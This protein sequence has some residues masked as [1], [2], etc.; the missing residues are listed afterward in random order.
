[1]EGQGAECC[2]QM[3][4]IHTA[5]W[6][7][8]SVTNCMQTACKEVSG[9]EEM[10]APWCILRR[11]CILGNGL[12][13]VEDT[14]ARMESQANAVDVNHTSTCNCIQPLA[15]GANAPEQGNSACVHA[16]ISISSY[17][18]L[19]TERLLCNS[20][21]AKQNS[22][23]NAANGATRSAI[24]GPHHMH[25]TPTLHAKHPK[26]TSSNSTHGAIQ[27]AP[28]LTEQLS[29]VPTT[30]YC[31]I[32]HY[33]Q[34]SVPRHALNHRSSESRVIAP[35]GSLVICVSTHACCSV[36]I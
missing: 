19:V 33:A 5:C 10:S 7:F 30:M 4:R 12:G 15:P 13:T 27:A 16:I 17:V 36:G 22:C 24:Y 26:Q 9:C 8:A 21:H 28:V 3:Q 1:M 23:W 25:T 11:P 34:S 6:W 2:M 35:E 18:G 31:R 32:A 29:T 20:Q 14:C